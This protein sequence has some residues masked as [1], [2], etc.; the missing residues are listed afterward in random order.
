MTKTGSQTEIGSSE[1]QLLEVYEG[2]DPKIVA[3]EFVRRYPALLNG[4]AAIMLEK[5]IIR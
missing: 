2:E 3:E 1:S 4:R 5:E